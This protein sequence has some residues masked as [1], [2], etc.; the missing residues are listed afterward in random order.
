MF[1]KAGE[2]ARLEAHR[3]DLAMQQYYE[4]RDNPKEECCRCLEPTGRT[5]GEDGLYRTD[6]SGPYCENCHEIE[7]VIT[8]I[9]N[10]NLT[11]N[12]ESK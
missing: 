12:Q 4:E 10:A 9:Q 5:A 8:A 2:A 6:G 7:P 1:A 11:N 3:Q